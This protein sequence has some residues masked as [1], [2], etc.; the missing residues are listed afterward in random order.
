MTYAIIAVVLAVIAVAI[1]SKPW[2]GKGTQ[3]V[4]IWEAFCSIPWRELI[5][6]TVIIIVVL[7]LLPTFRGCRWKMVGTVQCAAPASEPEHI[8]VPV[9]HQIRVEG[10][11]KKLRIT[12]DNLSDRVKLWPADWP[13]DEDPIILGETTGVTG[14]PGNWVLLQAIGHSSSVAVTRI[15]Q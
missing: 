9:D 4:K 11:G 13:P 2:S 1:I 8:L 15:T 10:N 7:L 3:S 6:G 12:R 14:P 5:R